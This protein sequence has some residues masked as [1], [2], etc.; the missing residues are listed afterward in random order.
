MRGRPAF[1]A[2]SGLWKIHH[3]E[4]VFARFPLGAVQPKVRAPALRGGDDPNHPIDINVVEATAPTITGT[5]ATNDGTLMDIEL[6][7]RRPGLADLF[8]GR[9]ETSA[10][11]LS[12][13]GM[14]EFA[15]HDS[16]LVLVPLP[17]FNRTLESTAP[18]VVAVDMT[19]PSVDLGTVQF[20]FVPHTSSPTVTFKGQL[21]NRDTTSPIEGLQIEVRSYPDG[22]QLLASGATNVQGEFLILV[23]SGW[24]LASIANVS[25]LGYRALEPLPI[26]FGAN[27]SDTLDVGTRALVHQLH[28]DSN[29]DGEIDFG[30]IHGFVAALVG[31]EPAW[32]LSGTACWNE[33]FV[34]ANDANGDGILDFAD[35][36]ALVALL[37]ER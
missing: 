32:L 25:A 19:Q 23:P 13:R 5:L 31:G 35:I 11:E 4:G 7:S 20:A 12:G 2:R 18:V 37:S 26:D 3:G 22:A 1:R 36:N 9:F 29:C 34:P 27:G 10:V 30:D 8:L 17:P 21:V 28:G 14:L 33:N 24:A 6:Y 15:A 16:A